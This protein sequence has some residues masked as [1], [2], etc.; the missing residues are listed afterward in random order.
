MTTQDKETF[1]PAVRNRKRWTL[2]ALMA[3][4]LSPVVAAWLWTPSSFRNRGEL[5]EPPRPLPNLTMRSPAGDPVDLNSV[6]GR[7]TYV[8]LI[9]GPCLDLCRQVASNIERARL[10]QG[11]NEKRIQLLMLSLTLQEMTALATLSQEAPDIRA[12][13]LEPQQQD[14]L[15]RVLGQ[16]SEPA[17][18]GL[19]WIYLVDPLGNLMMRYPINSDAKDLRKDI[20]R[21]LRA[22]RIG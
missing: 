19:Q 9:E 7:W 18:R 5:V 22:S 3:L 10:S 1:S 16:S 20:G 13:G 21:L 2:I 12:L 11:K 15:L 17:D 14:A 4:F 8:L 6:L